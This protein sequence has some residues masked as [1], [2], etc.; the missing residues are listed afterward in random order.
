MPTAIGVI[1]HGA[2]QAAIWWKTRQCDTWCVV[3]KSSSM[4]ALSTRTHTHIRT[5]HIISCQFIIY[6]YISHIV[7]YYLLVVLYST[8]LHY[9]VLH[10]IALQHDI[11]KYMTLH[12][13]TWHYICCIMEDYVTLCYNILQ[14]IVL[15]SITSDYIVLCHVILGS[16]MND[17]C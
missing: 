12:D 15:H 9:M 14:Y 6:I 5:Y 7:L 4:I 8:I 2:N 3:P 10:Y 16:D 11:W 17:T 1:Q 13:I